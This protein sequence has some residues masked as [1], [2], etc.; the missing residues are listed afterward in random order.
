MVKEIRAVVLDLFN[1]EY[2]GEEKIAKLNII[3]I[4]QPLSYSRFLY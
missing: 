3:G 4:L 2:I 1:K